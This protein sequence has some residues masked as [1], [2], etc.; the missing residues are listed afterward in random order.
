MD[1][2]ALVMA[3][4]RGARMRASGRATPKPLVR[5]GGVELLER[6]LYPLLRAGIVRIVVSVPAELPEIGAFVRGRGSEV[7]AAGGAEVEILE[8]TSPLGNIGCAG[9]LR[10]RASTV[11]VVYADNLT[12]LDLRDVVDRHHDAGN[13]LTLA[14][15]VEPF[16]LPYGELS[17]EDGL[18][19][20]YREKPE[21]RMLVCSAVSVLGPESLAV[22]AREAPLGLVDLFREL[23]RGGHRVA[24]FRHEA[25]WVDVNDDASVG[26]A[27]ELVSSHRDAFDRWSDPPARTSTFALVVGD[28]GIL[29]RGGDGV[30]AGTGAD[31][32]SADDL[33]AGEF[34]AR[35]D[36]AVE[37]DELV[38]GAVVRHRV[39]LYSAG[40]ADAPIGMTWMTRE[41]L[42][43]GE[44]SRPLRRA[45][46]ALS[47]TTEPTTVAG[48]S[49]RPR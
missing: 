37:F 29:V 7:A 40:E 30:G 31:L 39:A 15:H 46:A 43:A 38:E 33:P 22:A 32:P 18:V 36:N 26:R 16:R 28:R 5:V 48:A 23:R 27:E 47:P 17:V 35:D 9:L 44:P 34:R 4:G 25:P 24:E 8:E 6:N 2:I 45:V 3:G 49:A 19:V 42:D 14:T 20:D 13:D 41:L 21:H 11:L 12:S 1:T 10:D